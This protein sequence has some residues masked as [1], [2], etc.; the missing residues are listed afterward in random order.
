MTTADQTVEEAA[1]KLQE[2]D[3]MAGEDPSLIKARANGDGPASP[4]AGSLNP[5]LVV[6]VALAVGIVLAKWID[7]REHA[8]SGD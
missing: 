4:Q 1:D 7:R 8:R 2:P 6:G 3:R 5:W